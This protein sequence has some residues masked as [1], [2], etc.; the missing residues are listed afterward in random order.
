MTKPCAGSGGVPFSIPGMLTAGKLPAITSA[1]GEG[2][3]SLAGAAA[4]GAGCVDT[5]AGTG[6]AAPGG[7]ILSR[8]IEIVEAFIA[9]LF[10]YRRIYHTER[11]VRVSLP[12]DLTCY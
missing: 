9:C 11:T 4:C 10:K 1:K 8:D 7:T 5:S 2:K 6:A 3:A 12:V